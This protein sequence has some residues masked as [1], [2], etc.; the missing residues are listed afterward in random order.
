MPRIARIMW[1]AA[2]VG[3]FAKASAAQS[4]LA[5]WTAIMLSP[6]GA[7]PPAPFIVDTSAPRS[8]QIALRN[9]QWRADSTDAPH[10]VFGLTVSRRVS[11]SGATASAVLGY[12]RVAC[13][14]CKHWVFGGFGAKT[15]MQTVSIAEIGARPVSLGAALRGS[16]GGGFTAGDQ[17]GRALS[18]AGALVLDAR[19]PCV[20]SSW[21]DL[22]LTPAIAAGDLST[23]NLTGSGTH[24][25]I[26][27]NVAWISSFGLGLGAGIQRVQGG[28]AEPGVML[29]WQFR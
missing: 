26:G 4:G 6:A 14:F 3:G 28:Q 1:V 29:L 16:V 12:V 2:L 13:S 19:L 23:D 10:N 25:M 18:A 11:A 5:A 20:R 27:A 24:P 15:P 17:W 7:L 9:G 8:T 21:I 22:S